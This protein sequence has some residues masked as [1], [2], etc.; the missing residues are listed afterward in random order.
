[1][2]NKKKKPRILNRNELHA[3]V[4]RT[5]RGMIHEDKT[6][7]IPRKAKYKKSTRDYL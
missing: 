6:K 5:H 3:E 7:R 1:M 2:K 4:Q